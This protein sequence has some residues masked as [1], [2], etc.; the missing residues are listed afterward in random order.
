M[1]NMV[2]ELTINE[3]IN[4]L[5]ERG[6][7]IARRTV[8]KWIHDGLLKGARLETSPLGSYWL[9][10]VSAIDKFQPPKAG[11]PKKRKQL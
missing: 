4:R 7:V 6:I 10:P 2:K 5:N 8:N 1:Q 9:I 11:R 3:A